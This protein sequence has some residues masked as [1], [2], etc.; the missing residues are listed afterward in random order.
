[1]KS[2]AEVVLNIFAFTC[3]K[4]ST[5]DN[6]HCNIVDNKHHAKNFHGQFLSW[7]TSIALRMNYSFRPS[8]A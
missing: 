8:S 5:H 3:Y 6:V 2:L 1:M 7:G 4:N